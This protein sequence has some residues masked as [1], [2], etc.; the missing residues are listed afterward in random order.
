MNLFY[1]EPVDVQVSH[2]TIRG[3]EANHISKV[4]RFSE[5]DEIKVTDGQGNLY[6]C[7]IDQV[8]KR[9]ITAVIHHKKTAKRRRPHLTLCMGIIKKRDRLEFAV[10][11]AIELGINE[12][13]LFKGV[14][15]Q[16]ENVRE[17]RLKAAALSAMKQSLRV[18]LPEIT[19]MRSLE[20]ALSFPAKDR[21]I[22]MA[23]E[24][25]DDQKISIPESEKYFLVVGPEGGFSKEERKLLKSYQALPY[26]LGE[27]D[28][29]PKPPVW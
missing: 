5:G 29:E 23:D 10:E 16:K 12:I 7:E 27:K 26:S 9:E 3:Q 2:I 11:K 15:S 17:D 8:L 14:Y 1:A 13:V 18:W 25:T 28:C 4:L 19:L 6:V 21:A 20:E 24:T 22:I